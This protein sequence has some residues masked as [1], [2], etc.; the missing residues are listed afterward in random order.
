M[1]EPVSSRMVGNFLPNR[2]T[3]ELPVTQ[4]KSRNSPELFT[5]YFINTPKMYWILVRC[6]NKPEPR[7]FAAHEGQL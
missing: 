2:V 3:S 5:A 1:T 4:E 6:G 7:N